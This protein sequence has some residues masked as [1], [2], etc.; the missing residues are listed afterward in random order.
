[1]KRLAMA[2]TSSTTP[3][4]VFFLSISKEGGS[5]QGSTL[6]RGGRGDFDTGKFARGNR[7]FAAGMPG[8]A[9]GEAP[10]RQ[11]D[12]AEEAMFLQGDLRIVRAG[13]REAAAGVRADDHEGR[14]EGALVDPDQPAQ[15]AG[16]Q[17]DDGLEQIRHGPSFS[18][19]P[20]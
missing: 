13:R 19:R 1:M 16:G 12:A 15:G 4:V 10:Q 17:A 8:A 14:G 3:I 9:F 20:G 11:S 6:G 5:G 2:A 7:V 18:H